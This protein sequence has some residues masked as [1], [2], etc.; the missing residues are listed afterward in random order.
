MAAYISF[1]PS[2]FFNTKLYTGTGSSLAITGVGFQ[3]DFVW[4]KNR[5][6]TD[7]H[8]LFDSPRGVREFISSNMTSVETTGADSLNSFD[9][10]GFTLGTWGDVNGSGEDYVSW[11]WKGGTT[12]GLSGGTITPSAYSFNTTS[13]FGVYAYTGTG[14][15]ATIPHGLGVAPHLVI[16]KH[17]SGASDWEVGSTSYTSWAYHQGLNLN[18][19]ESSSATCWNSTAPTSTVFSVGTNGAINGSGQT[20]IAYVFANVKGYSKFGSYIANNNT[21]GPFI[22]TGFSP[23][24]VM[25]YDTTGGS[26]KSWCMFDTTRQPNNANMGKTLYAN[27]NYAEGKRGEGSASSTIPAIDIV[28][29]GFKPRV[30]NDEVN[31]VTDKYIYMAFAEFPFVSSNSIPTTAR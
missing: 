15:N 6:A 5:D 30:G 10:D 20:Y 3:P 9:S 13:G 22:Y 4:T 1:Q 11:N 14:A 25:I 12:S 19:A 21:D 17:L 7:N 8:N 2:D 26:Y 18:N 27:R 24:F 23:A 16:V 29:N 28:S 31:T